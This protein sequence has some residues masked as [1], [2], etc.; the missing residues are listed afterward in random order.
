MKISYILITTAV[1]LMGCSNAKLEFKEE[2]LTGHEYCQAS[3]KL[4][5]LKNNEGGS[6]T[7]KY[8][9]EDYAEKTGIKATLNIFQRGREDNIN[10]NETLNL[11]IE[12]NPLAIQVV[13]SFQ[14]PLE[15]VRNYPFVFPS[16]RVVTLGT[17]KE[18]TRKN[19]FFFLPIEYLSKMITGKKITFEISLTLCSP[20]FVC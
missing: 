9:K 11:F 15:E 10:P 20:F 8:G 2:P 6:L 19:M 3:I 7:L 18:V 17:V 13:N 16:G 12:G 1:I 5:P 14:K 4:L